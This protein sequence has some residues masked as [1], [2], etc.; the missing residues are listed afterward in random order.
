MEISFLRSSSIGT[1]QGYCQHKYFLV[2]VLGMEDASNMTISNN[3]ITESYS[4]TTFWSTVS[5]ASFYEYS[6]WND[7]VGNP[8]KES[9]RYIATP[10]NGT[11]LSGVFNQGEGVHHVAVRAVDAAGNT[12]AWSTAYTVTYDDPTTLESKNECKNGGWKLSSLNFKNQGQCI[13]Y[14]ENKSHHDDD[15]DECR[16]NN[17]KQFGKK[18]KNQRDCESDRHNTSR[19]LRDSDERKYKVTVR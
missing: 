18:Y 14:F 8:Y 2:Y 6:Y 3:G 15:E 5:D 16:I 11:S 13:K 1:W 12:S 19:F 17:W 4:V 7:I 10:I 9:S